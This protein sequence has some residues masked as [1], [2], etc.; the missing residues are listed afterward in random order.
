MADRG[1]PWGVQWEVARLVSRGHCTWKDISL[2]HLDLL[3][4]E[5]S[6]DSPIVLNKPIAPYIEDLFR[7]NKLNFGDQT[8]SKEIRATVC[9][10]C[11]CIAL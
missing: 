1:L 8:P 3:R 9:H 5:G 4:K 10:N 2:P 6:R 7:R 11:Y